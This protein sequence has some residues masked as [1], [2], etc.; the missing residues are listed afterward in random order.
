VGTGA[1]A[2]LGIVAYVVAGDSA[3]SG[4]QQCASERTASPCDA[5][6]NT[7]RGWDFAAAGSWIGAAGLGTLAVVLWTHPAEPSSAAL[8][9]GPTSL[10]LRGSF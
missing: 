7:V 6:K 1:L 2:V 9:V 5:Q 8:L 3:T 4:A 10:G